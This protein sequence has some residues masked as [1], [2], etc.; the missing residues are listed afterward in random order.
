METGPVVSALAV[1]QKMN[2]HVNLVGQPR[3]G[4]EEEA[5]SDNGS[6]VNP[7]EFPRRL[8]HSTQ[9]AHGEDKG[10]GQFGSERT[11]QRR[12]VKK[13]ESCVKVRGQAKSEW[14]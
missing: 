9:K 5:R 3:Q 12:R 2:S 1:A 8:N 13:V 7:N 11:G 4:C 10:G 6:G 14:P